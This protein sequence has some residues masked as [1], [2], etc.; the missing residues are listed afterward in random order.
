MCLSPVPP[1]ASMNSIL[2]AVGI[3]AGS[4]WKPSR[5]PSSWMVTDFGRSDI[6]APLAPA[7]PLSGPGTLFNAYLIQGERF[8][9]QLRATSYELQ[10]TSYKLQVTSYKLQGTR[11]KGQGTRAN[12]FSRHPP[13]AIRHPPSAIRH[14]PSAIN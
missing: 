3:P 11:D 1:S 8:E 7:V 6:S 4:I 2:R 14:P 9:V 13:S 5:G 12:S 10:V